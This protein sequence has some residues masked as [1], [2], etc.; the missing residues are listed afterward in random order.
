MGATLQDHLDGWAR[1]DALRVDVALAVQAVAGAAALLADLV[2]QGPLAG[3]PAAVVGGN[4]DGDT[5]K[6]L[7]V[8]AD[9]LFLDVL[10]ATPSVAVYASEENAAPIRLRYGPGASV[11]VAI[12]PLDG[13]SNIDTNLS[14]GTIFSIL[15]AL[16]A[17]EEAVL[18]DA[19]EDPSAGDFLRPGTA[20][21]AA[22][23][24]VYGPQTVLVLT[25]RQGT[26]AF[27]LDRRRGTFVLTGPDLKIPHGK[28]E[29]AI[30]ASNYRH[31]DE[32]VRAYIDDCVAGADGPRGEDF[33]MRW[34]AS[35]VAEAFRILVR[36]GIF[37]YPGDSRPGYRNGRLRLVYEGNP[38]ALVV[39]EA[40]GAATDGEGRILDRR[41][42]S[43]HQ[44]VPLVFG[45]REKVERVADYYA[46]R[47][48]AKGD[49][50]PLFGRRGLFRA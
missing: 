37:L 50:S 30:N 41:P 34:N 31:W 13:S 4:A 33:N 8:R 1:D 17:S 39:E 21:L 40:G 22:G 27:T 26:H 38:L 12:D 46:G 3:S 19:P 29:Y 24:V 28:R 6:E 18:E 5:Q 11:V 9:G 49:R 15:P 47:L 16:T 14:I 7:D 2:A 25:L 20:Q 36:G 10:R 45:C 42:G 44:R 32:P 43:L 35:L 23:F 48:T